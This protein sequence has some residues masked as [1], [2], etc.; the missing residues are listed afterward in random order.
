MITLAVGFVAY[1]LAQVNMFWEGVAAIMFFTAI[2]D[3]VVFCFVAYCFGNKTFE[4]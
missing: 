3:M 1:K 4:E 2:M